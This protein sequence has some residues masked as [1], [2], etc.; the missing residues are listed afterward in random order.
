NRCAAT[1]AMIPTGRLTRNTQRQLAVTSRPPSTGPA[2]AATADTV[3]Q[4]RTYGTRLSGAAEAIS[5]PSEVGGSAAA[6]ADC[7]KRNPTSPHSRG[8]AA[9]AAL[10]TVNSASP[11][12]NMFL[13]PTLSA[14][15]PNGTSSAA[16]MIA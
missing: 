13:R 3:D 7:T 1:K 14:R 10:A 8:A 9:Q 11:D 2:A 4:I 16:K 5:R 15:R 12:R 6:P